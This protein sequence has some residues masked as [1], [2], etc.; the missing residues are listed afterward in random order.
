MF[1]MSGIHW[2]FFSTTW[3]ISTYPHWNPFS[4]N[5]SLF[6]ICVGTVVIPGSHIHITWWSPLPTDDG[7]GVGTWP[8]L[9]HQ[10]LPPEGGIGTQRESHWRLLWAAGLSK[11][12]TAIRSYVFLADRKQRKLV[13][14][15]DGNR[16]WEA[17]SWRGREGR[18]RERIWHLRHP[19]STDWLRLAALILGETTASL[20]W[21]RKKKIFLN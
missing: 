13:C 10:S 17:K 8:K 6:P 9:D 12:P 16:C 19:A 2:F 14:L 11:N 15:K 7:A 5:C 20:N 21:K 3:P 1:A 4:R 18:N